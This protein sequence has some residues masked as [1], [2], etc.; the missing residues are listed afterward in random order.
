MKIDLIARLGSICSKQDVVLSNIK[1]T[2]PTMSIEKP[3]LVNCWLTQINTGLNWSQMAGCVLIMYG[4]L[5]S[6]TKP[7]WKVLLAHAISGFLGTFL[8]TCFLANKSCN[9]GT[10]VA[11]LLGLNEVNWI[12]HESSTVLYSL[13]KVAPVMDEFTDDR[14]VLRKVLQVV[15]ITLFVVFAAFRVD[16]GVLRVQADSVS[17]L[18]I[19]IA[20]SRAFVVWGIAD[21]IIL[22]L[23]FKNLEVAWRKEQVFALLLKDVLKS[24]IPRVAII[25]INT[26]GIVIVGNLYGQNSESLQTYNMLLWMVKGCY[27]MILLFD[28]LTTQIML[29]HHHTGKTLQCPSPRSGEKPSVERYSGQPSTKSLTPGAAANTNAGVKPIEISTPSARASAAG[30]TP[31]ETFSYRI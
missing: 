1:V 5:L 14:K 9:T 15:F 30:P 10:Y 6:A 20:H 18:D 23:I 7:L 19:T 24:S 16:I 2:W 21:L 29:K 28:L 27:P 17:G 11:I 22:G 26:F 3:D 4:F 8:E 25:T 12:I 31:E 13:I